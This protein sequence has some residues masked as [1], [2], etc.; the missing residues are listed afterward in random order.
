[1][2]RKNTKEKIYG[3]LFKGLDDKLDPI[4]QRMKDRYERIFTKWLDDPAI[5]DN[6]MHKFIASQ[7]NVK[8]RQAYNDLEAVKLLLGNV[9][10]AAKEWQR[11]T[12]IEMIKKGYAL[13]NRDDVSSIDV[14]RALAII[15]AGEAIGKVTRLDKEDP[16]P[17]P[18]D[19]IIPQ[20]FEPTGDV[21][22]LGMKKIDNLK[23]LQRRLRERFGIN[24]EDVNII[25][26][27]E[28]KTDIL[29]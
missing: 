20:S 7:F 9:S 24:I 2:S 19:E 10:N 8:E 25:A 16:D 22:I 17:I 27:N 3:L 18:W 1:M 29:Q 28:G 12:A 15:K 11:Y 13:L 5:S 23:D 6:E 14:R 21:T 26:A 4:T